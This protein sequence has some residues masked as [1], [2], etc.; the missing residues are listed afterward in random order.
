MT[1]TEMVAQALGRL[2][3]TEGGVD[4]DS[5][6]GAVNAGNEANPVMTRQQIKRVIKSAKALVATNNKDV[7]HLK[8]RATPST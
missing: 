5:I 2:K 1:H 3:N 7:W 4:I 8:G 6:F